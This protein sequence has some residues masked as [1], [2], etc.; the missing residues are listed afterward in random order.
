MPDP[1]FLDDVAVDEAGFASETPEVAQEAPNEPESM[2]A[3]IDR[4]GQIESVTAQLDNFRHSASSQIGR[5]QGLQ[6]AVDKLNKDDSSS[7]TTA[8]VENLEDEIATLSEML[9]KAF[10][11]DEQEEIKLVLKERNL[12]RRLKAIESPDQPDQADAAPDNQA[13]TALWQHATTEAHDRV[14]KMG[15]DPSRVPQAVYDRAI[16]SGSPIT[17]IQMVEDWGRQVVG[18]L[19]VANNKKAANNG[20]VPRASATPSIADLV[21]TYGEGGE[22]SASEKTRVIKHLGL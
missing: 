16:Q 4:L 5:M 3:V 6:S 19:D 18:Q 21:Q 15:I 12:D 22:I 11:D 1:D 17:A 8:R 9:F 13:L 2:D 20:S 14:S 10:P 7:Q